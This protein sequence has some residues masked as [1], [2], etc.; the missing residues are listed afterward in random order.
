[1]LFSAKSLFV[2]YSPYKLRPL[3]DVVRGKNVQYAL[4]W[5]RTCS[6]KKASPLH[7]TVASAAANAAVANNVET[8][9]L[10]IKEIRVD[11]GPR[12]R[13]Y[14]PGAQGRS[15]PQRRLLSHISVVLESVEKQEVDGGSKG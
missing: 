11:E 6:L 14:R 13:Y 5:L 15:N 10:V 1:M 12:F 8:A 3:A 2:R 7:K 4:N 9:D